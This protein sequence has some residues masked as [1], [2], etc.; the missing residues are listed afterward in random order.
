MTRKIQAFRKK[1]GLN[2]TDFVDT[3][4]IVDDEFKKIL[5]KQEEFIKKRNSL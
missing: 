4:I 5:K 2:K 3:F 1:L